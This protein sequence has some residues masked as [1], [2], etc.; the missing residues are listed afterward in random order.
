MTRFKLFHLK[1]E[2]LGA[3]FLANLFAVTF[4]QKMLFRVEP[5]PVEIWEI[6]AIGLMD[7][8]FTPFAFTFVTVGTL[9][10]EKPIRAFLNTKF[11]NKAVSQEL[12][13]KARRRVLNEPFVLI[14]LDL[15][16]WL[17]SAIVYPLMFSSYNLG[18]NMI[19]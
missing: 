11:R 3:N 10:Y 19:Q 18:S 17:L 14:A 5:A 13:E 7:D 6:P 1:N 16:M 15:S 8:L 4:V 12:E 2:M 9:L